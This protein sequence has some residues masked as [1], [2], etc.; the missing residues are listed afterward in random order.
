VR[1]TMWLLDARRSPGI[2]CALAVAGLSTL[3]AQMTRYDPRAVTVTGSGATTFVL[4]T[5]MVGGIA[6]SRRLAALLAESNRV[7]VI[8]PYQLAIDSADVTFVALARYVD[9]VLGQLGIDSARVAGHAHG[10]GTAL[11]L[12]AQAPNRVSAL[13]FLDGAAVEENATSNVSS[14]LKWASIIVKLPGGRGFVRGRFIRGLRQNSG[15]KEWLDSTTARA[16]TEIVLGQLPKAAAMAKRLARAREPEPAL[17]MVGRLRT[18]VAV[19]LGDIPHPSQV[20][21]SEVAVLE[22]LGDRLRV[23]RLPGVGHFL[24]EE[25]PAEVAA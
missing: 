1:L 8:D 19:L 6:G 11:R 13:Y 16:Y 10:A 21:S 3:A 18:P 20:D 2:A 4:I 25:M 14:S 17:T 23:E 5:G 12:A 15:H 7:V 24:H 22:P 9:M